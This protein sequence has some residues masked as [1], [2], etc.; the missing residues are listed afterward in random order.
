MDKITQM[1]ELVKELNRYS[2]EYYTL[3]NPSVLDSQYDAKYTLLEALEKECNYILP[4]SPTQRIGDIIL[5]GFEKH[6]HKFKCYS[7][8]KSQ[9]IDEL[10]EWDQ[11]N[12][13]FVKQNNLPKIQ[14]VVMKKFD[15]LTI[16]NTYDN[17][18]LL[19]ASATR[20]TGTVGELVTAQVRTI[21]SIP[22]RI[23]NNHLIEI[24]GEALMT[25]REFEKYNRS[26]VKPLK[27]QRNGA[28]GAIKNLDI[29]ESAKRKLSAFFYDVGYSEGIKFTTYIEM[30]N[31]IKGMGL[32]IDSDYYLCDTIEEVKE[33]ID[34]IEKL[35]PNLDYEIDGAIVSIND[36]KTRE[37]MGYA[38]KFPRWATA[39]KYETEE[40]T[41][42]L[43]AVEFNTGR[44][45]KVTPR[46]IV[47]PVELMGATV[48]YV[49]LN[50]MDDIKR[51]CVR[52]GATVF[53]RRSNDVIP[54]ILGVVEDS[55]T[56][57][58][59]DIKMP[60]HCQSCGSEL[61]QDGVHYFCRNSL[62]CKAQ[63]VKSISHFGSLQ[64][65]N[66]DGFSEQT[67][68]LFIENGIISKILD[69]FN[70]EEKKDKI[71]KLPKFG[72]KKYN[73][74]IKSIENCKKVK[75]Q[76]FIFSLGI[77]EIGLGGSKNLCEH[78]NNNINGIMNAT[79]YELLQV[80]D[81]GPVTAKNVHSYFRNDDNYSLVLGLLDEIEIIKEEKKEVVN[82]IDN[83]FKNMHVYPSGKFSL[84]KD[85]LKIKLES[86]GAIVENGYKKSL[87]MLICG[88]D[89]SK[90]GK[91][92][93]A[94][95][96]GVKM[97]SEEYL[98][99]YLQ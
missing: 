99:K 31:F 52:I 45:G 88:G 93:K 78:F 74:L 87:D 28:A 73:N 10:I 63:I 71:I 69:L 96:D 54:E 82:I 83:P 79:M 30:M 39:Y 67:A 68:L 57:D 84:K 59:P 76:S 17:K 41:T 20:G 53:I 4:D 43:L 22:L 36:I 35:R 11:K 2:Y 46:G 5:D 85:E 56:E 44:T 14:Y 15:G 98:M 89:M 25:K 66:I 29:K 47:E 13:T 34:L 62:N 27:N 37:L 12:K 16:N 9:T 51:K 91:A 42:E 97:V 48:N 18:G 58:M 60:I 3:S 72:L 1:Q 6:E 23:S 92:D 21:K 81:I 32:P 90:S 50:S 95:K 33:K 94:A 70:L 64:A 49:T 26:A 24:H 19:V 75:L 55:V 7:M 80:K 65:M 77:D 86:L 61:I 8:D 40:T 38:T